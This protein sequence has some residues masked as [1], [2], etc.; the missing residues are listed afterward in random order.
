MWMARSTKQLFANTHHFYRKIALPQ[1]SQHPP[2]AGEEPF[3]K[4]GCGNRTPKK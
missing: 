3:L 4:Q 2:S 1:V